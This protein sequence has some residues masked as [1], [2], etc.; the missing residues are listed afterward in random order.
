[1]P[2]YF[3]VS[4]A[5]RLLPVL[6]NT[7]RAVPVNHIII[8]TANVNNNSYKC[9]HYHYYHHRR[10]LPIIIYRYACPR[11]KKMKYYYRV[12]LSS[13]SCCF[14]SAKPPQVKVP[15]CCSADFDIRHP[16]RTRRETKRKETVA[17]W[18]IL[19]KGAKY[20]LF[21]HPPTHLLHDTYQNCTLHSQYM[22]YTNWVKNTFLSGRNLWSSTK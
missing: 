11:Y 9:V 17:W 18:T 10:W 19:T 6:P 15:R 12:P 4:A 21:N 7:I 3:R 2:R 14:E 16:R 5:F 22:P 1:M 8:T 20:I 13:R